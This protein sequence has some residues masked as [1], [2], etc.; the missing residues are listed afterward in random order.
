MPDQ[1]DNVCTAIIQ[2]VYLG[3]QDTNLEFENKKKWIW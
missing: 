3:L 1:S 2:D